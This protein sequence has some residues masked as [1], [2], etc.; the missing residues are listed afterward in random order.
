MK[1]FAISSGLFS[2]N[3]GDKN[4]PGS[5]RSINSYRVPNPRPESASETE[6]NSSKKSRLVFKF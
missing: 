5:T 6:L 1:I 3:N 2:S 4:S